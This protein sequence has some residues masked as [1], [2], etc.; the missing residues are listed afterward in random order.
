MLCGSLDG[1]EVLGRM[2]TCVCVA[3]T[4]KFTWNY[5]I[6]DWLYPKT[7][8]KVLK[9]TFPDEVSGTIYEYNY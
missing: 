4:L 2:D 1:R 3:E 9:K 5:D 6:I 7:K 8:E